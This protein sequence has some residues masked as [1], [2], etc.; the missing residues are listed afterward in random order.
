M[1][2]CFACNDPTSIDASLCATI[3]SASSGFAAATSSKRRVQD[4]TITRPAQG[5]ESQNAPCAARPG[6]SSGARIAQ[7]EE[8]RVA[9]SAWKGDGK[10]VFVQSNLQPGYALASS[11]RCV[12]VIFLDGTLIS[13]RFAISRAWSLQCAA[14]NGFV[15]SEENRYTAG[16]SQPSC[17]Q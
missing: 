15:V 16:F 6:P 11:R 13:K 1:G 14:Q 7:D 10:H 2:E 8:R 5:G 4:G 12:R 17:W 9:G 3:C